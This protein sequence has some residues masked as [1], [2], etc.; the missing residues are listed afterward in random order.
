[1]TWN[2]VRIEIAE[3]GQREGRPQHDPIRRAKIAAAEKISGIPLVIYAADFTDAGR[4]GQNGP[5]VQIHIDD[6]TGFLQALSDIGDGPLDVL[7]HSPGGSPT[8]TESIVHLL[9]SRFNPIRFMIPHTA[10]SAATMLALSG[11]YI[12]LGEAAELGPID[13]QLQ[14]IADQRPVTVPARAAIDQFERYASDIEADPSKMR[15]WLPI[16]R[17]YG[18][19]FLQECHNAIALSET[20]VTNWLRNY[21][22]NGEADSENR[23]VKIAEWLANHNN[24]HS[25]SRPVWVEQLLEVEPTMKIKR[26]QDVSKEFEDAVMAVYWAIDVTFGETS[27]IKLIEHQ[28]GSAYVKLIRTATIAPSITPTPAPTSTPPSVPPNRAA[29]RQQDRRRN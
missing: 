9:R 29:R 18:P 1:V 28:E 5:G 8:A 16:V 22:F 15:V 6:K 4:A 7:L 25:H 26:L 27:A 21:M 14:F 23:A 19:A 10:K 17:Q 12:L 13:P 20:L 3:A 24:F 2:D 11:D